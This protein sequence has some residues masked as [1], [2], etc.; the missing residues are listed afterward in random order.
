[1]KKTILERE[2][3]LENIS[4][5]RPARRNV[6]DLIKAL[7]GGLVAGITLGLFIK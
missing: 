2:A 5:F 1:M 4:S 7:I 3:L 6:G